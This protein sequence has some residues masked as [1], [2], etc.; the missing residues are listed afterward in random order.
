MMGLDVDGMWRDEGP[1]IEG[2]AKEGSACLRFR[3]WKFRQEGS[4]GGRFARRS[5]YRAQIG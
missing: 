5:T 3:N 1:A 2:S 4:A